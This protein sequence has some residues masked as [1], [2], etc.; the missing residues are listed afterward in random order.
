MKG[1][2]GL[3]CVFLAF[4]NICHCYNVLF[5]LPFG[6]KSHKNVFDPVAEELAKRGHKVSLFSPIETKDKT[7]GVTNV[8]AKKWLEASSKH[9]F[10]FFQGTMND[11]SA[12]SEMF[13]MVYEVVENSFTEPFIEDIIK[14]PRDPVTNKPK[15][16]VVII[17]AVFND[18][19]LSLGHHMG[20]PTMIFSP[21]MAFHHH[22]WNLNVPYPLSY[23]PSLFADFPEPMNFYQ[24]AVSTFSQLF[25]LGLINCFLLPNVD[26]LVKK[27]IP[28]SPPLI[29]LDRNVSFMLTNSLPTL[30][31][32]KPSMPYTAEV[33]G[34]NCKPA[35]PLPK[36]LEE[37]MTS[38]G[39]DGVIYFS[40]GS[41][42]KG[43]SMP[44]DMRAKVIDVF[45]KL[46]Q[47]ILWK[48]EK[49]IPSL[50]SNIKLVQWAPQ[51]DLL[52]NTNDHLLVPSCK[53]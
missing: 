33:G 27:Y 4:I 44:L 45:S 12:L 20:V 21:S 23:I 13:S 2:F 30:H 50:P 36:D 19:A 29:E 7:P 46:P 22:A 24:R 53:R 39:K 8:L 9:D 32:R 11:A 40:L 43:E 10:S 31:T 42:T 25:F 51:Q 26:V 38:A 28:N 41:V 15:F 6:S 17:D 52:G 1:I 48:Y 49:D 5:M 37:F 16:D 3:I 14:E 34:L 35:Q 18:F 47:K